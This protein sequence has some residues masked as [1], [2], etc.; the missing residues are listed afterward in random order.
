MSISITILTAC[1]SVGIIIIFVLIVVSIGI[2]AQIIR[3]RAKTEDVMSFT[4][5]NIYSLLSVRRLFSIYHL[6]FSDGYRF[7]GETHPF[8][9]IGYI[10]RG[11]C[12][13]T[14]GDS[15]YVCTPG[16]MLVHEPDRFHNIWVEDSA[17]CEMFTISFDGYGFEG[18]LESGKY[19]L[20]EEERR[21]IEMILSE[22]PRLFGGYDKTE[23]TQ[24][25][26]TS[27][28]DNAGYQLIKS[29]L[30]ILCLSIIRRG[31]N[32]RENALGDTRSLCYAKI[33]AF[34]R[35][36][37]EKPL[38]VGDISREVFESKGKIKEIFRLFT[39]GGVMQYF[40]R[41]R[42][43]YIMRRISKGDTV[44]AISADMGFSS[45]AYL[46]YFFKRETGMT[47]R[48]YQKANSRTGG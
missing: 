3:N 22:L 16:D 9:E 33:T 5:V 25:L 34:L 35:D 10:L 4:P 46:S 32:A 19:T 14:S 41:L 37:V 40:N 29:Y 6:S 8:W 42:C 11:T 31:K 24:L 28:P 26:L 45:P 12:G 1:F 48:E 23:Y 47:V 7:S 38:T 17:E 39:G 13:I 18:R 36:N 27:S 30:E 2:R 43:E 15:V 44:R 21:C 20:S